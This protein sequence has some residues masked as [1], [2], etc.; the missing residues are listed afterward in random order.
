MPHK[1]YIALRN[2]S[3]YSLNSLPF[4]DHC[5][6]LHL[7]VA[8]THQVFSSATFMR[9]KRQILRSKEMVKFSPVL[10]HFPPLTLSPIFSSS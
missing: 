7:S 5:K 10:R 4:S 9:A 3:G 2:H 1:L 8:G 6:N